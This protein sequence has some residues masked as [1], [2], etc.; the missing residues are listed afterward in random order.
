MHLVVLYGYQ[1]ADSD[2]ER[3]RS[4][5]SSGRWEVGERAMGEGVST[6]SPRTGSTAFMEQ[7]IEN[8]CV[9]SV[10]VLQIL[11]QIVEL[12]QFPSFRRWSGSRNSR[13]KVC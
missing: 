11:E 2:A 1:G 9:L 3:H 12:S 8:F 13:C 4:Q 7:I 10:P 6:F 5:N